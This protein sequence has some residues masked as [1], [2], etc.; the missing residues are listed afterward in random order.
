ME[1]TDDPGY[2]SL[3]VGSS[4]P[5]ST[6]MPKSEIQHANQ[7]MKGK[8]SRKSKKEIPSIVTN[9]TVYTT[10]PF[11]LDAVSSDTGK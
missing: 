10:R 6:N 3:S 11:A 8:C 1:L 2:H 9:V 7:P 5:I 4:L